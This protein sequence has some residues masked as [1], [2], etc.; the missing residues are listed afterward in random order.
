M[1]VPHTRNCRPVRGRRTLVK[2]RRALGAAVAI[3]VASSAGA[4]LA[5]DNV[6]TGAVNN[7]WNNPGNWSLGRVPVAPNGQP[8]P[9]DSDDAVVNSTPA[10][11]AT[12]TANPTSTP[13][14]IIVGTG[15]G[16]NGT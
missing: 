11:V 13:R 4:A 10:N 7:D 14:D 9:D 3:A 5:V 1:K 15:A 16:S 6:W 8:A 12:I 2:R